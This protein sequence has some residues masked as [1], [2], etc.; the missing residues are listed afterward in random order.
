MEDRV[1]VAGVGVISAIGITV[2]ETLQSLKSES[3]GISHITLFDSVYRD[4]L[5]VGEV[6]LSNAQLCEKLFQKDHITRTALLGIHAARE[7]VT[8][9]GI[10]VKKWR[11]GLISATTVGGM[12]R[13]EQ[14]FNDFKVNPAKGKLRDV[15]NHECGRS[16][17]LIA[18]DLGIDAFISTINTACS[19]SVNAIALGA[20]LIK[21]NQLDIVVAGGTDALCKFTLNGFNSLMILDSQ[22]C[23]PFDAG[24]NGL[25]LGEGAGFVVIVSDRVRKTEKR[26][27]TAFVNGYGNTNDAHHQTASSPEGR[28]SF[29]AMHKALAMGSLKPADIDYINLHGTGTLNNDLS[30]GT[31]ITRIYGQDYPKL[32]STKAFTGHTLGASGGIEAVFSILAIENQCVFPNLRFEAPIPEIKITPQ[33]RYEGGIKIDHVMSNSFGFGGNCSS[34]IFSKSN[35]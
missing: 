13:T 10:D 3:S 20:R 24:R 9:S 15:I 4:K 8:N 29:G 26:K 5:P 17:E 2:D 32:S 14:F 6:K 18:D 16:T 31:A 27:F 33:R 28:G 30:E 11:T 7:A 34:I 25:N 35:D 1:Y 22:P 21:H 12:D 23:R 19:S